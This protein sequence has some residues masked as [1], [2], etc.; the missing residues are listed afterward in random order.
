[1]DDNPSKINYCY[2]LGD[3]SIVGSYTIS[4]G[5]FAG[6]GGG[7]IN[8]C[9][10]AG[11][12]NVYQKSGYDAYAGGFV[13][14]NETHMADCYAAGN[15]FVDAVNGNVYPGA[16][17]GYA[18]GTGS[19]TASIT[20]CFARGNVM[21]LKHTGGNGNTWAGGLVAQMNTSAWAENCAALG[22]SV[23]ITGPGTN[24]ASCGRICSSG[25]REN[26]HANSDMVIKQDDDYDKPSSQIEPATLTTGRSGVG[27]HG[28]DAHFGHFGSRDFWEKDP[29]L[30]TSVAFVHGTHGLGFNE[31]NWDFTKVGIDGYPRLR[32]SLNGPVMG[33]Q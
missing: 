13:G 18:G 4:A 25:T 10:A 1:M 22:A 21:A 16:L 20:R 12:V 30:S 33:G 31:A 2:A 7:N 26:N 6:R 19:G 17:S 28:A 27:A 3:I 24:V 32:A 9:Y 14:R 5:G 29:P 11:K 23:T 8:Y 15:V